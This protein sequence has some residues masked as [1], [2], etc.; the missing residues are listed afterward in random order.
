MAE[1][2]VELF[3]LAH[4]HDLHVAQV[5]LQPVGL[6]LPDAGERV[7][8]RRPV[9]IQGRRLLRLSAVHVGR[10]GDV[11]LL[12]MGQ[13]EVLHVADEV[14]LADRL[15]EARVVQLLLADA[16][17]GQAAVVMPGID[18][19]ALRQREDLLAHRAEQRARVAILEVGA[20]AAADEERIAGE[21]HR[22]VVEHVAHAAAGVAGGRARFE[23]GCAKTDLLPGLEVAVG[24]LRAARARHGDAAAEPL[25]QQPG[26]GDVV[27]VQ[28]RLQRPR[29]PEAQLLDQRDV[30]PRLLEHRIDQH[31]LARRG[32]GKEVGVC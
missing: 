29:Q 16:G 28:M 7:G 19:A 24:A 20:A 12:R 15:P 21:R 25:L 6:N 18:Q 14:L 10:D 13:A 32:I 5:L 22:A 1:R 30:A 23:A 4:I 31:R 3:G 17:D 8:E 2:T 9:G 27:G 26:A 11:H